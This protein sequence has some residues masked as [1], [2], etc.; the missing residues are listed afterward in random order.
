MPIYLI[1]LVASVF[2]G[3]QLFA[4]P[5]PVAQMTIYRLCALSVLPL[6]AIQLAQRRS[7]LKWHAKNPSSYM[8]MVLI[9]WWLWAFVSVLWVLNLKLWFQTL[10]LLTLGVSSVL[11]LY[12][13]VKKWRHWQQLI[14]TAWLMMTGLVAWGY[15]ELL[16]GKYLFADLSKLYRGQTNLNFFNRIPITTFANQNDYAT[17]LIAYLAVS[18]IIYHFARTFLFKLIPAVTS[19]LAFYLIYRTDSRMSL[20]CA[21]L[22]GIILGLQH[23]RLSFS[24]SQ[25]WR[26]FMTFVG[27][28]VGVF[29]LKPSLWDKV[30]QLIYMASKAYLSGDAVRVNL[31]RNGLIFLSETFGFGVGAGNIEHWMKFYAFLPTKNIVNM[32]SWWFEILVGY[33]VIVFALYVSAYGLL[34]HRLRQ[35]TRSYKGIIQQTA[36]ALSAYLW[37]FIPASMTS[38]NNMLIEWHWVFLGLIIVFIKLTEK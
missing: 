6:I 12:F 38:A 28:V 33:G 9:V 8:V 24:T 35:L 16:T 36:I 2:L 3:T 11:A 17:L 29:A 31:M 21:L 25:K 20:A 4:I 14:V 15:L 30:Q 10:F 34:L 22:L 1:I 23:Y 18:Y 32:H 7:S 5:T 13:W 27:F 26:L 37:V 19:L